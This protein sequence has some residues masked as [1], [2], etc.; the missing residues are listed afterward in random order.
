MES[1]RATAVTIEDI[2]E[3]LEPENIVITLAFSAI[4][5]IIHENIKYYVIDVVKEFFGYASELDEYLWPG[6]EDKYT[7]EVLNLFPK[8][9]FTASLLWLKSMS[10]I[11]DEQIRTLDAVYAHR[12]D[13]THELPKYLIYPEFEI[14]MDLFK[15]AFSVLKDLARFF[16]EIEV[17]YGTFDDVED[18]DIDQVI[19]SNLLIPQLCLDAVAKVIKREVQEEDHI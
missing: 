18:F 8:S 6:A 7:R 9:R 10:A 1:K 15:A 3:K 12:H 16:L 11:T 13:L 19:A 2:K 4:Y 14:N 17:E 5:Q